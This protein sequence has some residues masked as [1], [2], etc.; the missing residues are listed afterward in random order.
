MAATADLIITNG[1]VL[2]IDEARPRA[3][4]V[5]IAG[6]S[7]LAVGSRADVDLFKGTASRVID[8]GGGTV[9]PGLIESHMHLFPGAA[10]MAQL[11]LHGVSGH[12]ALAAALR[13]YAAA[14]PQLTLLIG[15]A[16]DY[17]ILGVATPVT[18]QR[19]DAIIADRP[20]L[21]Y[22]PD[23]HTAWAN[24]IALERAGILHGKKLG[25]GN[26]IVMGPDGLA[27]G[28]LREGEAIEP[29]LVLTSEGL[30]HRLGLSTGGD[31]VP[32]ATAAERAA[33]KATLER[34]LRHL[35]RH[36]ITS[37]HNMDGNPYQLA[38]LAELEAEGKLTARARIP[39]HFKNF[40]Q[41]DALETASAM[42][43]RYASERLASGFVK[44]FVDGVIDSST[45]VMLDG[46]ADQPGV[47]CDPL[48]TPEQFARVAVEAD[49]RGLQ[50]AVHAIGDGA[51]R[52]VLNGY[53]AAA[54]ANGLRDLRHRI[55]HIELVHPDDIPRF[56]A[57]GVVASMQPPHAPGMAGLPLEPTLSRIGAA[58]WPYAYA[59]RTLRDAGA[60]LA[61]GTD[62]PVSP[63]DPMLAVEC[64]VTRPVWQPG[65]PVQRQTLAETLR[66]YTHDGAYVEHMEH[67]KGQLKPGMLADVT[68]LSADL[69]AIAPERIHTVKAVATV[70]DGRV[71][72]EA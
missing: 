26:E 19:L 64:A 52:I 58:R 62:W 3:E 9:L 57:L 51:V 21:I 54:K 35:A 16:A 30:R 18:R 29:V 27:T 40:M 10:E 25:V 72:Y 45:A 39:F 13:D 36:G 47:N 59:W 68:V 28:E 32:P 60:R 49:R 34:G 71:V 65:L 23:H 31:P 41:P 15:Q 63:I 22:S 11:S 14:N 12:D 69:E 44:M 42:H 48:F 66:S 17:T 61:F 70:C 7:I 8:A 55:E 38:L 33:D 37:F 46:Y 5:A 4:A 20:V 24:T 53:A 67:R 6:N 43:A 50:I 2:T 56:K 1:R